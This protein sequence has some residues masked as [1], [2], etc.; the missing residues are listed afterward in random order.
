MRGGLAPE[1]IGQY[2]INRRYWA[3]VQAELTPEHVRRLPTRSSVIRTHMGSQWPFENRERYRPVARDFAA[4]ARL[5]ATSGMHGANVFGE[6][7]PLETANEFNYLA[8]ATFSS[9]PATT[10]EAFVDRVLG[11]LLG[12]PEAA[13]EYLSILELLPHPETAETPP[14][15]AALRAAAGRARELTARC[16]GDEQHRRW[17]WLLNRLYR[18][19]AMTADSA[20]GPAGDAG[21]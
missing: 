11:P 4:L 10:W 19:R 18:S 3:R 16:T 2:T 9:E 14:G 6:V 17:V 5:A 12:G 7:S 8:F 15:E 21:R 20:A 13:A 1:T